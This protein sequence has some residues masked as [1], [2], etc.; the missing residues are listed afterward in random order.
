MAVESRQAKHLRGGGS[1]RRCFCGS[2]P[3]VVGRGESAG[4]AIR[5]LEGG[6]TQPEAGLIR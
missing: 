2:G 6:Q 3:G 5:K 4:E 1:R